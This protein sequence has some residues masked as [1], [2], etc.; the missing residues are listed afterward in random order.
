MNASTVAILLALAMFLIVGLSAKK[1]Q[2]SNFLDLFSANKEAS[3]LQIAAGMFTLIGAGELV[4]LSTLSFLFGLAGLFLFGGYAAAFVAIGLLGSKIVT[5]DDARA[6]STLVDY[7]ARRCGPLVG[8]SVLFVSILAFFSLLMLQFSTMGLVLTQATGIGRETVIVLS[9]VI[10]L[11]Y[12][13]RG[14]MRAVFRT[15][16]FQALLMFGLLGLFAFQIFSTGPLPDIGA[17]GEAPFALTWGLAGVGFLVGV[18]SADVWQRILATDSPRKALIGGVS[19]GVALLV[20]GVLLSYIGM[21]AFAL[22]P[23][24]S[25]DDAF[26]TAIGPTL[27]GSA[28]YIVIFLLLAAL[29]STADTE[30]FLVSSLTT[31]FLVDI[32]DKSS[33]DSKRNQIYLAALIGVSVLSALLAIYFDDLV[34]IYTWLLY[35]ILAIS[36]PLFFALR[37]WLSDFPAAL[38][39]WLN[40]CVIGAAAISGAIVLENIY[41]LIIPTLLVPGIVRIFALCRLK[42]K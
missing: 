19:G 32:V 26:F 20:Y 9:C 15:D 29:L 21:S 22:A 17:F 23:N 24:S 8:F 12:V 2:H 3:S 25:P 39:I 34:K 37:G 36:W 30:L 5:T 41:H 38:A 16:V 18:S 42:A 35:F 13:Y 11:L 10:L 14:G 31:R 4:A 40:L 28:P 33:L 1:A 27:A 7:C 6:S